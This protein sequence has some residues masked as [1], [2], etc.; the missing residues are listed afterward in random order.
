MSS[1]RCRC[2]VMNL[3]TVWIIASV[4]VS[5]ILASDVPLAAVRAAIGFEER[6]QVLALAVVSMSYGTKGHRGVGIARLAL[7]VR[8]DVLGSA[9]PP[10]ADATLGER[11]VEHL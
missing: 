1:A 10:L 11:P 2:S 9:A 7:A 6:P 5:A 3:S 8:C 4:A